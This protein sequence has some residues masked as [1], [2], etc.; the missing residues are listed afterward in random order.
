[1]KEKTEKP[2]LSTELFNLVQDNQSEGMI[3]AE[4]GIGFGDTAKSWLPIVHD[5]NGV[6]ILVD[7]LSGGPGFEG[8]ESKVKN[9]IIDILK[10]YPRTIFLNGTSW[11][12]ADLVSDKTLDIVYLDADHRYSS[13]YKDIIAWAPKIKPGGILAGHDYD[14]SDYYPEYIE[15][16]YFKG[17]HSGVIKAVSDLVK[18]VQFVSG[19]I[20]WFTRYTA[21]T[22]INNS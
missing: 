1:M 11:E 17:R 8:V 10:Q 5:N 12:M 19:S 2:I 7:D 22:P 9:I 13:V 15:K 6:G 16:D 4:I 3:V 18:D 21:I 20:T 14:G